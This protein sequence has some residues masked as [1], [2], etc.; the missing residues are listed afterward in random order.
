MIICL[1]IVNSRRV[2]TS[3]MQNLRKDM[4]LNLRRAL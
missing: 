4:N 2:G 3:R 1:M